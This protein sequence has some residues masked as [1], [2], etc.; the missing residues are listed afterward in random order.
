MVANNKTK[1][2]LRLWLAWAIQYW[3]ELLNFRFDTY[4]IVQVLPGVYDLLLVAIAATL[5]F[6][7][8]V[9][10]TTNIWYGFY[11]LLVVT[12]L[13]F[14]VAASILRGVIELYLVAFRISENMDRLVGIRDT[15]DR[16]SGIGDKVDQMTSVTK[17]F[18]L[19]GSR[20]DAPSA[21]NKDSKQTTPTKPDDK[22]R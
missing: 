22:P 15:V 14:L 10:F 6:F 9:A 21:G 5:L 4:M 8:V 3:R 13:G 12:P 1:N 7:T 11:F 17:L 16:L 2:R 20:D 18:K 19:F